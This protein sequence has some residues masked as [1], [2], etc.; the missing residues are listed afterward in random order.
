MWLSDVSV[1]RPVF[2]TVISLLLLAFGVLSF[3][4]LP[5]REYPDINPPVVSISTSYVGASAEIIETRIT[6]VIEDQISGIEGIKQITSSSRDG[7]SSVNIEFALDRDIDEAANDVRDRVSRIVGRLP[8]DVEKPEVA[9]QDSDAR[10]IMYISLSSDRMTIMELDDYARRYLEDRFAV[11]PGV[12]AV[13]VN[14]GR[15]AMRIWLDRLALAARNLTVSDIEAALR[16]ENLELPAGRLESSDREFQVRLE[17]SYNT[18]Q[19]FRNLVLDTADDGT[20]VRLGEVARVELAP[21]NLRESFRANQKTT[22]G[23]GIVKQSTA[24]TLETLEAV[25]AEIARVNQ[26]LPEH[27]EFIASSDD[28]L[29]IREAIDSVYQ[30]IIATTVLVSLVILAFLGTFRTMVIPAV[31]IPVCLTA[32]F[33]ALAAFGYSVNLITLLALV[34]SIGLVVDDAIVVLENIHRRI[35]NG[36]PPLLAAFNGSRQVAFAVVATTAVLVAVFTPIVFLA[37]NMGVIFSELAVTI[38]AA[39]IF[40]SVLALSLTPVMCSKILSR[41]ERKNPL[42]RLVE[43]AFARLESGYRTVLTAFVRRSWLAIPLTLAVFGALAWLFDHL[44]DEYAPAEDQGIFM[45]RIQAPE[46]TGIERMRQAMNRIEQPLIDMQ[47]EGLIARTLVRIPGWGSSAPNSG[48]AVVTMVPWQER[49]VTTAEAAARAT[50]AWQS[51][52]FVQAFAFSR[53][54]LSRGGGNMPVQ[55]VLGGPN[56]DELARWRDLVEARAMEWPGIERIDSDLKETQPQ[57]VVRIDKNRAAALGVSVQNVGRTLSAMM[58]EQ[59]V[60]TF[61]QDGEEYDVLLQAR[62]DQRATARDLSNIY[63]RSESSGEL[64]PLANLIYLEETAGAGVLNRYNRLRAVTLSAS[65]APGY[66]LGEAL[67]FL[68]GVVR[69]EL[70]EVAQ[71]DYKGE[72]LEFKEAAGSLLFTFG[73]ALLIVFLVLAAQFESFVHPLVI[74][75][76]VPLAMAGAM[77]GLY[78]TGNSINIYS[79]IGLVMLI[80]IAAKN[81]VLIVEFINQLRDAGRDF[82]A[83]IIE[84]AGIR[85][86]PVIMTTLSTAIGALPLL[87][88]LGAGAESRNVLGVVIFSGVTVASL[89]TLFVVPAFYHLLARRSGSPEAVAREIERLSTHRAESR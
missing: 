87:F 73:I 54:G 31:T 47:A 28:S 63:V 60:T 48:V 38:C 50:A 66:S 75:L 27:M 83:A 81:G 53:S 16:R 57:V 26:T 41:K 7:R 51:I 23:L 77:L 36:E 46:G 6:Q 12:A 59:R 62:E 20:L 76:T 29:F 52:P 5:L 82:E 15:P 80:G 30:T 8:E 65:L 19:D 10:P 18:P 64:I 13:S 61:V 67:E 86:R 70:P 89:L 71:V 21:Q 2:A 11:I 88:A 34:L 25:K 58:S 17:R 44:P 37:D 68:E 39:V 69:D 14:G 78:L 9:K 40:S 85:L 42:T 35:E 45:A 32:A 33:I 4:F 24:N 49:D 56:Y 55:F 3:N 72:S 22:V 79:Q 1:K 43:R 84:A 74:I